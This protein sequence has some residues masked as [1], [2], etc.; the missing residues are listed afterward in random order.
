MEEHGAE[1]GEAQPGSATRDDGAAS[2]VQVLCHKRRRTERRVVEDV[3]QGML[4]IT[5]GDMP[6]ARREAVADDVFVI[7]A[8]EWS[9]QS[10]STEFAELLARMSNAAGRGDYVSAGRIQS[11]ALS[12]LHDRV[13]AAVTEFD[14][15][16]RA[17]HAAQAHE[18]KGLCDAVSEVSRIRTSFVGRGAED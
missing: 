8:R 7:C 14:R 16:W 4:E 18:L 3:D 11:S 13:E 15:R 2:S 6:E 17:L 9:P 10:G 1:A 12:R 5:E